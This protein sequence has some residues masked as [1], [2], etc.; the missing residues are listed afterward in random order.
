MSAKGFGTARNSCAKL[1][2]AVPQVNSRSC[3]PLPV[4]T[5]PCDQF[6]S[7]GADE[8]GLLVLVY[9]GVDL[10]GAEAELDGHCI[11]VAGGAAMLMAAARV[12]R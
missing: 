8:M 2:L 7:V 1:D 9:G 11:D 6:R 12:Y 10:A 3:L 5:V 4:R